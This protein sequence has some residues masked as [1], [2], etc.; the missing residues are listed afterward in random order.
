MPAPRPPA[1]RPA[2]VPCAH[3]GTPIELAGQASDYCCSGCET[4]AAIIRGAGLDQY[5]AEREARP[6]RPG[7]VVVR[8]WDSVPVVPAADGTVEAT[9]RLDGLHCA[10][11]VWV[12]EQLMARAEGV[13]EAQVSYGSGKV[14]LRFD[15]TRT[16]LDTILKP[17]AS[18][19][20]RPV[21][22]S[23]AEAPDRD[24]LLRLGVAFFGVANVMLLS[25]SLYLGWFSGMD[26]SYATL[27]RW[28][29]LVISA[30]VALWAAVPFYLGALAGL[31]ART[32]HMDLPVSI[33]VLVAF[34]HGVYGA[35]VGQD[36]YLDSLTMLVAFLLV[37]RLLEQR[38]RRHAVEAANA[39]AAQA[40][41]V[42]RR[43]Q[44]EVVEEVPLEALRPGERVEVAAGEEVGA[45]GVVVDG[46]GELQLALLTGEAEPVPVGPGDKVV[47]GAVLLRGRLVVQ[48]E[49]AAEDSLLRRMARGLSEAGD[50]PLT[51]DLIDRAAPG[52]TAVTLLAASLTAAGWGWARGGDA[53]L[54][55][56]IAVLVVACPCALSL[57]RPLAVAAGLGAAA[58]RGLLLR[59]GESLLR[60]GEVDTVVLDKTGTVTGGRP[61][62]VEATDEVLRIAAGV[63]RGS[64]H[65][66]ARAIVEEA[67][68]RGIP[69]PNGLRIIEAAG[70]G[71]RG[72]VDGRAY[73]L[74]GDGPGWVALLALDE[75]GERLV[76]RLRLAD[77]LRPDAA[78]A[79]AGLRALGLEVQLLTGDHAAVAEHIAAEAG[80]T[81]VS[82]GVG[83]EAKAAHVAALQ[84][85]GHKVLFVGDG[86][87]DGP[88]LAAAHVGVA[89]G[90]GAASSVLVADAVVAV[91]A[92]GPVEA[93]LRASRAAHRVLR[94]NLV[95]SLIYNSLAVS[96][97]A[98]GLINPLIAALLM[99]ASSAMVVLGSLAVEREVRAHAPPAVARRTTPVE[100][101]ADAAE[102]AK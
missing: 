45:D 76:G 74:R 58:R 66:V 98:A 78:R 70:E 101:R 59:N 29:I 71:I 19:G 3:C 96:A 22:L 24:L 49:L 46:Q 2:S 44:G 33:G 38:G 97:A 28:I 85:A 50:K 75:G 27:F 95:R 91:G 20:Y 93:G 47:T 61:V 23:A 79:V 90:S 92:L 13:H 6:D 31:R 1:A 16:N 54:Q 83:P 99:P 94:R 81:A 102:A 7:G 9:L 40:P 12:T 36:G 87:N 43:V 82:A 42:V 8:G 100:G 63:E 57:A 32:L 39:L 60:M 65:P 62:V 26:E 69:I 84:A 34:A 80:I 48:A 25:I 89:M 18:V 41:R 51:R 14:S 10:S 77:R 15:P 68:L 53:A 52:F 55:A 5:Y 37:G 11:C 4:A 73:R 30:P 64:I 17:V 56:T 35:V 21:A 86:L 67:V 88:A 72:W